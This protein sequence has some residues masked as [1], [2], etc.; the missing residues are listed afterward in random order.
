MQVRI[1]LTSAD[2]SSRQILHQIIQ[3]DASIALQPRFQIQ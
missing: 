1:T 3:R 2:L